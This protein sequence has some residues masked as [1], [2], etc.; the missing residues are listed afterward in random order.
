MSNFDPTLGAATLE[1]VDGITTV[2][3]NFLN[4]IPVRVGSVADACNALV[5]PGDVAIVAPSNI[6]IRN[7]GII[8]EYNLTI[9]PLFAVDG[10]HIFNLKSSGFDIEVRN[11][12]DLSATGREFTTSWATGSVIELHVDGRYL[13]AISDNTTK[14]IDVWDLSNDS[15]IGTYVWAGTRGGD[16]IHRGRLFMS[17]NDGS[18]K[19]LAVDLA[20][21]T[22]DATFGTAGVAT[23]TYFGGIS[24][25]D[26]RIVV[27]NGA[28]AFEGFDH[29]GINLWDVGTVVGDTTTSAIILLNDG[30]FV[31]A[32]DTYIGRVSSQ[33]GALIDR[34]AHGTMFVG[35]QQARAV[36]CGWLAL[37]TSGGFVNIYN[38][39]RLGKWMTTVDTNWNQPFLRTDG[40]DLLVD[41]SIAAGAGINGVARV[42]G[43]TGA[44]EVQKL[45]FDNFGRPPYNHLMVRPVP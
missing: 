36:M 19:I 33:T 41:V 32:G 15:F 23:A 37:A 40:V 45:D 18:A 7:G 26:F 3:A 28:D 44:V 35:G 17:V 25:D 5:S 24:A 31:T 22:L 8:A 43:M 39:E 27:S 10:C 4:S 6:G 21:A 34:F 29:T 38:I 11:A 14:K 13:V 42:K 16:V 30:T 9:A 12:R 1:F 2:D 20:T